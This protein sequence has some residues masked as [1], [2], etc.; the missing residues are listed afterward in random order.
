MKTQEIRILAE[1]TLEVPV[2]LS[3]GQLETLFSGAK[4]EISPL[5]CFSENYFSHLEIVEIDEEFQ[6]YGNE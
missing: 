6:I 2:E 1:I 4:I 5:D 3:K